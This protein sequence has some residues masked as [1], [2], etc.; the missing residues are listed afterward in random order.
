MDNNKIDNKI[1]IILVCSILVAF[2]TGTFTSSLMN[3][4]YSETMCKNQKNQ[5]DWDSGI[6]Y[7]TKIDKV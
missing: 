4:G 2:F 7:K 5:F 3:K 1:I 6:C